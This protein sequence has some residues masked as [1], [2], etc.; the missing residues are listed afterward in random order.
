VLIDKFV[1]ET[2]QANITESRVIVSAGR[3]VKDANGYALVRQLAEK[4]GG[5]VGASRALV[6]MGLAEAH[7]QVGQTGSTVRPDLYVACGISGAIQHLA[8][9]SEA[10]CIVAINSDPDA[11]IFSVCDYGIVGDLKEILPAWNSSV[12][13]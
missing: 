11:E 3:G 13:A 5:V 6:E 7:Q 9:M 12:M 2:A 8:G 1:N 4:L 10:K